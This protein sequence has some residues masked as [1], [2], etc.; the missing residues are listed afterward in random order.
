MNA[1]VFVG[2]LARLMEG[3]EKPIFLALDGYPIHKAKRVRDYMETL[4]GCL[5]LVFLPHYSPEL[6]P[7][8]QVFWY[9][10]PKIAKQLPQTMEELKAFAQAALSGLQKLPEIIRSFFKHPDCQYAAI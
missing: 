3:Q 9:I 2:F 8:E 7:D 5:K 4:A 10:K 1:D 6:N